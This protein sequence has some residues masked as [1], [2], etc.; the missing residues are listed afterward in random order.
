MRI[1]DFV[2]LVT[3]FAAMV[4]VVF[5][6][7]LILMGIGALFYCALTGVQDVCSV[8]LLGNV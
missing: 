2:V 5:S 7:G 8:S 1:F 3:V 4:L 6:S